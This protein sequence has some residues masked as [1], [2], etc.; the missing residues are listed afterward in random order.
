MREYLER[1]GHSGRE[2]AEIA[3][4]STRDKKEVHSPAEVMAAHRKLAADFGHQ[5]DAVVRTARERFQ[6][7]ESQSTRWIGFANH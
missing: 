4:H 1:T 5:A 2:A 7:Q 3:A 6:H